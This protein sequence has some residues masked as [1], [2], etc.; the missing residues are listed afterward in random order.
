ML[1]GNSKGANAA[2]GYR[3]IAS[4]PGANII[5]ARGAVDI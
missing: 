1:D 3:S 4:K 5:A 2:S